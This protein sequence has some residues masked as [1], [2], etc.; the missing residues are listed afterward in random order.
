MTF[1]FEG[2]PYLPHPGAYEGTSYFRR[3]IAYSAFAHIMELR[4]LHDP[5]LAQ[6]SLL[7][8][9]ANQREDGSFP[10]HIGPPDDPRFVGPHQESFYHANW[11]RSIL[12]LLK[13]HLSL[14]FW[15]KI[16]PALARYAAYFTRERDKE[17]SYIFDV[18]NHFETGQE[19]SPRYLA[20]EPTCAK[21]EWGNQF[22]LKGVDAT[23]YAYELYRAL[24]KVARA[25]GHRGGA[26]YWGLIAD[27]IKTAVR[28]RMWDPGKKMFF[29]VDPRAMQR[30]EVKALTCFYPYFTDIVTK[31][32]L[33]GLRQHLF[34]QTEF[35]T[36]Y[37][38]PTLSID[39]PDFSADGV[40]KGR[41]EVCPWNGRVWSM[42]NSHMAEAIAHCAIRFNDQELRKKFV[43][44]FNKWI[45]TMCFGDDPSRPNSFEHYHP[46]NGSPSTK[47]NGFNDVN[48]YLHSWINDLIIKYVAG[49]RPQGNGVFVVD[50]F[51]F[52]IDLELRNIMYG[53]RKISVFINNGN[54]KVES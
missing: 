44:F 18:V 53:G 54:V 30:T 37:P 52:G 51:P 12:E 6:G 33:E 16:Y 38:F 21:A 23:V 40:W 8:F 7:N 32:H 19:F 15:E 24:S 48:D 39:N 46:F 1:A 25:L 14:S 3:H 27:D 49:F 10:G 42:T 26:I 50:P 22:Q 13:L 41:K 45:R 34:S 2:M 11:G 43:E 36:P 20:V 9:V 17:N 28:K 4:W 29:D 31:K 5:T 47:E 35:W